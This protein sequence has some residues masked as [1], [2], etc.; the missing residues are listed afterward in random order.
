MEHVESLGTAQSSALTTNKLIRNTYTLLGL[1]LAFS[2]LMAGVS[3]MFNWPPLPMWLLLVGV[4]GFPILIEKNINSG[5]SIALVFAYTGFLGASLGPILSFFLATSQG[6]MVVMQALGGTAVIFFGLSA[7]AFSTRKDFSFMGGF[8]CVGALVAF[9]A[10][11]AAYFFNMPTLSLAVSAAF[12]LISSGF[13]LFQTSQ[14]VNGGETNYV[15]AAVT[16]YISIFNL[17]VSL[18][19]LLGAFSG[20]D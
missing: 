17:F 12:V 11:I 14:I 19:R 6:S 3:M 1:T 16:L 20:R 13:I 18:L 2:A 7:Y 10:G 15:R 4:I 8:L 9:L 5:A